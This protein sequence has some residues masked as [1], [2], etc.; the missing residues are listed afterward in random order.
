M[1]FDSIRKRPN[2]PATAVAVHAA[3]TF[4]DLPP[5]DGRRIQIGWFQTETK[6]M[7]FN[8]SMTIPLNYV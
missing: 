1:G 6:G 3:Q 8:Q 2:F 7:P 4:S 5:S